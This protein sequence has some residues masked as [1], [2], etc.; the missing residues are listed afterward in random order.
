MRISDWSSDVCSS[1]LVNSQSGKGGVAWV[2]EQDKGLKLPKKMQASFSHVVQAVADETSRELG[3][4]DIW[5]AFEG[6]Y[7]ASEGK[8]FQL[9]DWAEP[10]ARGTGGGTRS[11]ERRVGQECVSTCSS[12][13]SPYPSKKYR[14]RSS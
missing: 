5:T 2:L 1:D 13:W 10:H 12:R 8:R 4:D 14:P 11:E 3:A 7:L 9:V 6:H